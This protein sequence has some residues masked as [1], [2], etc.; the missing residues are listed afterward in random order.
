MKVN[1]VFK[2]VFPVCKEKF[3]AAYHNRTEY[4]LIKDGNKF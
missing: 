4:N 3:L 2:G 1:K